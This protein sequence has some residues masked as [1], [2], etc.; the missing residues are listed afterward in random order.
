MT[1][2]KA[3]A[4]PKTK[5]ARTTPGPITRRRQVRHGLDET[6]RTLHC[7]EKSVPL[8]AVVAYSADGLSE[9][10][11]STAFATIAVFSAVAALMVVGVVEIGWRVRFLFEGALFGAIAL[12]AGAELFSSRRQTL[13][14]FTLQLSNGRE[15]T[16]VT[17]DTA[18]ALRL[19]AALDDRAAENSET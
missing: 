15:V 2:T 8:D 9:K 16:F 3:L 5:A 18:Q 17:A 7:G 13:F 12:C 1:Q 10:D 14:T 11:L 4:L 19:K 6:G